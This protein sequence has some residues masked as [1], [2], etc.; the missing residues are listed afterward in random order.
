MAVRGQRTV[1]PERTLKFSRILVHV[2]R[3]YALVKSQTWAGDQVPQCAME[4]GII[5]QI[6]LFL[7]HP[8]AGTNL[9]ITMEKSEELQAAAAETVAVIA[10]TKG[11]ETEA[12][13][14]IDARTV[15]ATISSFKRTGGQEGQE[16]RRTGGQG[17]RGIP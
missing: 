6:P 15:E 7:R 5:W 1:R 13:V 16:D 3:K 10:E 17:H 9:E 2:K 12:V 4:A 8:V 14:R 11:A